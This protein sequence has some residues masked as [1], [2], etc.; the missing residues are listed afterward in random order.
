MTEEERDSLLIRIDERTKKM[1]E[2]T[3]DVFKVLYGNGQPGVIS[4]IQKLEDWQAAR[5]HHYGVIVGVVGFVIN[6]IG[7]IYA[8]IKKTH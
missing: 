4:R 6:A 2:D 1:E 8:I 5:Q 7:V 3:K